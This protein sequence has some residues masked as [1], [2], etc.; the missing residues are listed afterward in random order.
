[1]KMKLLFAATLVAF[2]YA[3]FWA[4]GRIALARCRADHVQN[5]V[6]QYIGQQ[7][8]KRKIDEKVFKTSVVDIR[9]GL[10]EKYT[11]AE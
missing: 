9:R 4:G 3:A 6:V 7:Q 5:M 10:R 2:F 1:M 8:V 11:I